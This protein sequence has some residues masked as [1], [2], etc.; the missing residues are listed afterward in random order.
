MIE[1]LTSDILSE[2]YEKKFPLD[3]FVSYIGPD[4]FKT[5]EFMFIVNENVVRNISFNTPEK[6]KEFMVSN[7]V[8]SAYVGAVYDRPPSKNNRVQDIIWRYREFIFDIDLSDYDAHDSEGNYV[9]VRTCGCEKYSYCDFCWNLA[10]EAALFI[11]ETMK[12]DFGFKE[13]KWF[14][15]GRRGVHGWVMDNETKSLTNEQRTS[16]LNYL[17]MINDPTRSQSLEEIPNEAK[18]LR[19]RI[20]SLLVKPYIEYVFLQDLEN[21]VLQCQNCKSKFRA[22]DLIKEVTGRKAEG[23]RFDTLDKRIKE[24]NIKCKYCS[25]ELT[26]ITKQEVENFGLTELK[27][28]RI[29]KQVKE[30]RIF[31][32]NQYNI[33]MPDDWKVRRNVANDIILRR[34]PRIDKAVSTDIKRVSRLPYSVHGSTGKI[35]MEI[36]DIR[37]FYPDSAPTIWDALM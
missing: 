10:L 36:K 32:H 16:I 33:I 23:L 17:T 12:E 24:S 35:A 1:D 15:S 9:G 14:F 2:Y 26:N 37:N 29:I 5:R 25:S 20:F 22:Y 8:E 6:M 7:S 19:N 21:P 3:R 30:T 27:A 4:D 34:Y 18:P 13:M 11:D 28:S 31:D